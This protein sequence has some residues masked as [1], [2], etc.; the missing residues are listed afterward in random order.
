M[1]RQIC[2]LRR[3]WCWETEAVVATVVMAVVLAV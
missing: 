1:K 3:L 2:R